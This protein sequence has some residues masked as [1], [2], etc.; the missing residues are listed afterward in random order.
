MRKETSVAAPK[1]DSSQVHNPWVHESPKWNDSTLV[2]VSSLLFCL[3]LT[4]LSFFQ[5]TNQ[6]EIERLSKQ[7]KRLKPISISL[8]QSFR[9]K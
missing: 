8:C 3:P 7:G 6:T 4:L 1:P 5:L 9:V 2:L